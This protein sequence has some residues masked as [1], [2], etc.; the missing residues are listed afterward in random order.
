MSEFVLL[1]ASHEYRPKS[2]NR[3]RRSDC[4]SSRNC[5]SDCENRYCINYCRCVVELL[6]ATAAE[7]GTVMVKLEAILVFQVLF[8]NI[9]ILVY[10]K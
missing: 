2:L 6:G 8:Y 9:I 7:N 1:V 5:G 10:F 4:L 3:I